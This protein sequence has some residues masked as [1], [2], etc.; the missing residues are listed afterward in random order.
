MSPTPGATLLARSRDVVKAPDLVGRMQVLGDTEPPEKEQTSPEK[1]AN[2][3]GFDFERIAPMILP[4]PDDDDLPA[5]PQQEPMARPVSALAEISKLSGRRLQLCLAPDE[6]AQEA[7]AAA[8]DGAGSAWVRRCGGWHIE[9]GQPVP[10]ESLRVDP[11]TL[12]AAVASESSQANRP[13]ELQQHRY[14]MRV[15]KY[16]FGLPCCCQS[17]LRVV[18]RDEAVWLGPSKQLV[19]VSSR[20][21]KA[22]WT[23]VVSND[24]HLVLGPREEIRHVLNELV[25]CLWEA[26][27]VWTFA[28]ETEPNSGQF[29]FDWASARPAMASNL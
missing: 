4:P 21:R 13:W 12:L 18:T 27:W 19:A 28:L 6:A 25:A 9:L 3:Y 1:G 8:A 7:L 29:T 23:K 22:G 26:K 16:G 20:L 10:V 14:S 17:A 5:D 24:F 11:L 15:H 2:L